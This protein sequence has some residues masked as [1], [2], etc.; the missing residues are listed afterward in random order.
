MEFRWLTGAPNETLRLADNE[1]LLLPPM[2]RY[3]WPPMRR[4]G[5]PRRPTHCA[6]VSFSSRRFLAASSMALFSAS[7]LAERASSSCGEMSGQC[8]EVFRYIQFLNSSIFGNFYV[9]WELRLGVRV[10]VR[11]G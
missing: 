7:S 9:M 4:Y 5:W 6:A 10:R 1:T 2:R 11:I 8:P 3:G